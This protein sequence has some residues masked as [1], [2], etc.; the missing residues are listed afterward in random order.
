VATDDGFLW[1]FSAQHSSKVDAIRNDHQVNVAYADP[2]NLRFVSVSGTCELV[3]SRA[4]AAELWR[5]EY[6][7]FFPGGADDPDLILLKITINAAEYWDAD[8]N[9]MRPL[10]AGELAR[11]ETVILRDQRFEVA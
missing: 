10:E 5:P 11:N 1:F 3:R 6:N 9:T 2:A 7:R 4:I 8:A